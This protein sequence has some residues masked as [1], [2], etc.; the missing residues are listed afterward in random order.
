MRMWFSAA[1]LVMT[2]AIFS[3][4]AMNGH[5]TV[6][7]ATTVFVSAITG[8]AKGPVFGLALLCVRDC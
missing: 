5:Y 6:V 1:T 2:Y 4:A 7:L 3:V 8:A